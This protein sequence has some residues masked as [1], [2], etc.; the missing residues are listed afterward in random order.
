M[1]G[2]AGTLVSCFSALAGHVTSDSEPKA[3]IKQNGAGGGG[4][5]KEYHLSEGTTG[6]HQEGDQ[7]NVQ[8]LVK[9]KECLQFINVS[10]L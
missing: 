7:E 4:V 8:I 3:K 10:R 5:R 1:E 2:G 6:D 9:N